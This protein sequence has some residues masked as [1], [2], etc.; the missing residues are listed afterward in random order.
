LSSAHSTSPTGAPHSTTELEAA[1]RAAYGKP[2]PARIGAG[3]VAMTFT[4]DGLVDVDPAAGIVV[5]V[6]GGQNKDDC[7]A[8]VGSLAHH[9]LKRTPKG[10]VRLAKAGETQFNGNEYGAPPQWKVRR[11]LEDNPV[12][13]LEVGFIGQGYSC[14]SQDL[15]ELTPGG[16]TTRARGVRVLYDDS[17][18]DGDRH[19]RIT[20]LEGQIRPLA[21]GRRFVVVFHGT[22]AMRVVYERHGDTYVTKDKTPDAC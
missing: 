4:P 18:A 22:R 11:D 1:F 10:F 20:T 13:T 6:A 17:G 21:K 12:L 15:V 9:Y 19:H 2:S 14:A 3:D 8:C 5:L 16:A 7:H